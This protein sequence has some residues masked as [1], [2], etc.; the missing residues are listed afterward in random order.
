MLPFHSRVEKLNFETLTLLF[1]TEKLCARHFLWLC[2]CTS[3]IRIMCASEN[4]LEK[5]T[6]YRPNS[7]IILSK[8]MRKCPSKDEK[9]NFLAIFEGPLQVSENK[10]QTLYLMFSVIVIDI[11]S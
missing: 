6:F 10:G 8:V 1:L 2:V 5:I 3:D 4:L 11:K 9:S 7:A